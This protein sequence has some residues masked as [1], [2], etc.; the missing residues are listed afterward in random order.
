MIEPTD[1][2]LEDIQGIIY[3]GW[4]DHSHAG[5][6]FARLGDDPR[7]SRAWLETQRHHVCATTRHRRKTH[8][9]LHIALSP[10]GLAALGVPAD[11]IDM[12]A[13]EATAGM[14]SRRRVLCD[15]DPASWLIRTHRS[16]LP[17]KLPAGP[18]SLR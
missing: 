2:D 6:V 18:A 16:F 14:A 15:S 13:P 8:G 3:N 4:A 9:R 7:A 5:F 1:D 12:L 11:V 10:S 17:S